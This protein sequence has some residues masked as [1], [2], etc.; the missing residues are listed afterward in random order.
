MQV[1]GIK[2]IE[3]S[4]NNVKYNEIINSQPSEM[5][6]YGGIV[7]IM[8]IGFFWILEQA[9]NYLGVEYWLSDALSWSSIQELSLST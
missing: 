4:Y 9:Q 8:G 3:N 1:K 6:E 7:L 5:C 2:G